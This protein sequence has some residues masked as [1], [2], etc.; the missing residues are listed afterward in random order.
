MTLEEAARWT[1]I[2]SLT[3]S[4][5][6]H[7]ENF[8]NHSNKIDFSNIAQTQ[9]NADS[10]KKRWQT[11]MNQAK[12]RGLD[13]AEEAQKASQEIA[14]ANRRNSKTRRNPVTHTNILLK[15]TTFSAQEISEITGLDVYKVI[16][17]KLKSRS[18]A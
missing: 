17:L 12:N 9:N 14:N 6:P 5:Q 7:H 18:A 13:K 10:E 11:A 2:D 16:A 15:E 1:P 4:H 3:R 8:Q